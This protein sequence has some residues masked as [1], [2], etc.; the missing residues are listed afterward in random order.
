MSAAAAEHVAYLRR[1]EDAH[2]REPLRAIPLVLA[3]AAA[4]LPDAVTVHPSSREAIAAFKGAC[5]AAGLPE[6]TRGE[7][8]DAVVYLKRRGLAAPWWR[9]ATHPAGLA[10]SEGKGVPR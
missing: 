2:A 4:G 7:V 6:P 10:R 9:C 5:R 8:K 1:L 3:R